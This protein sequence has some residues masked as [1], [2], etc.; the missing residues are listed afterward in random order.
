MLQKYGADG[1]GQGVLVA[2]W[3]GKE[4]IRLGPGSHFAS[5]EAFS[6]PPV[7]CDPQL[8]HQSN[9]GSTPPSGS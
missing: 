3:I 2:S 9:V 4:Q 5:Y 8:P 7:L 1:R 6:R